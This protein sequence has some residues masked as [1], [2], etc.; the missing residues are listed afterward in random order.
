MYG[1]LRQQHSLRESRSS[2]YCRWTVVMAHSPDDAYAFR[3]QVQGSPRVVRQASSEDASHPH[4]LLPSRCL[5]S[6]SRPRTT[7]RQIHH[8]Q[9]WI[10]SSESLKASSAGK[11]LALVRPQQ[12]SSRTPACSLLGCRLWSSYQL[13]CPPT[14]L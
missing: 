8:M 11:E 4:I 3:M 10:H 12:G 14:T 1:T 2:H 7:D 5:T 13:A 9:P 6:P